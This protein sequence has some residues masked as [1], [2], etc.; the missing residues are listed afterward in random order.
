MTLNLVDLVLL[1]LLLGAFLLGYFQGAIRQLL[2]LLVW[3]FAFL[4]GANLR[5]P[6]GEW[7]SRYWTN[8]P[9]GY[10]RMIA[11]GAVFLTLLIVGNIVIQVFYKRT[12]ITRRWTVIDEVIGG[13]LGAGLYVLVLATI[14]IV[15]DS[16]YRVGGLGGNDVRWI[17]D[18]YVLLSGSFFVQTL[19]TALIPALLAIFGLLLPQE[20]RDV[21]G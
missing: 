10:S 11:F 18:L 3:L 21:A 5:E 17:R 8:L 9:T 4:I 13:L 6:L 7:F 2:G 19:K 12:P 20:V 1:I 15:L 16:F 14:V